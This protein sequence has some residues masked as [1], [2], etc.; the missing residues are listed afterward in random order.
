M[1]NFEKLVVLTVL[2]LLTIV[3]GVFLNSPPDQDK[4]RSD[5]ETAAS[6]EEGSPNGPLEAAM[7]RSGDLA[8]REGSA[9]GGPSEPTAPRG[10]GR[11]GEAEGGRDRPGP[12]DPAPAGRGNRTAAAEGGPAPLPERPEGGRSATPGEA[13][14]PAPG[15]DREPP[16]LNAGLTPSGS[17]DPAPGPERPRE[18][19]REAETGPG[20]AP[21]I[22][23]SEQGLDDAPT[24]DYRIYRWRNGDTWALLSERLYGSRA[25]TA[26]L[27][28]SNEDRHRPAAGDAILV[29][30]YDL[31][32]G[33]GAQPRREPVARPAGRVHVVE[34]LSL[35][36][37]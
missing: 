35:I 29:P 17:G 15:G 12:A 4:D 27:R 7:R 22:L 31:T 28:S 19:A 34:D 36:H 3:L 37:I 16:L 32:W 8:S 25:Y 11:S 20:G 23:R 6:A 10:P 14:A 2:F 26:L 1:G 33:A 24:R 30:V 21:R 18:P 13:S 9:R 5:G